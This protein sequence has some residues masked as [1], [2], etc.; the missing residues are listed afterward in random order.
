MPGGSTK[1]VKAFN[2]MF[3]GPTNQFSDALPADS[4]TKPG[5]YSA[6]EGNGRRVMGVVIAEPYIDE[7]GKQTCDDKGGTHPVTVLTVGCFFATRPAEEKGSEGSIWGQFLGECSGDGS[8]EETPDA[9]DF[10]K[11][12]LYKD[13]QAPDS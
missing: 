1:L 10:Y 12:V 5:F 9:F 13:Y 4:D 6:Y 2:T 8:I 11:I 3:T 7:D